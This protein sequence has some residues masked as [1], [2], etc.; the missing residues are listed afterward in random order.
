MYMKINTGASLPSKVVIEL[1]FEQK[2]TKNHDL[3]NFGRQLFFEFEQKSTKHH[4]KI[5]QILMDDNKTEKKVKRSIKSYDTY[6]S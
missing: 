1:E 5:G 6:V 3:L 2:S 4:A